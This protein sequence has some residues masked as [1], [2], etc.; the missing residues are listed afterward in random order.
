MI[1]C[2]KVYTISSKSDCHEL[3]LLS[4]GILGTNRFSYRF[5]PERKEGI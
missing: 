1:D 2:D 3:N 4:C 5:V